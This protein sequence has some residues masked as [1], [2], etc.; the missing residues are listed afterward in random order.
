MAFSTVSKKSKKTYYLHAKT[1][2]LKGRK[3]KQVIY[4]SAGQEGRDAVDALPAGYQVIENQRTGLPFL[5]KA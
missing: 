2:T 5:K 1:I 4:W 3:D